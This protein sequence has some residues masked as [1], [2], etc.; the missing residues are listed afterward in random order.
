MNKIKLINLKQ[1]NKPKL[2][3]VITPCSRPENLNKIKLNFDY[4]K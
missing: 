4:I 2:V 3:T 1:K